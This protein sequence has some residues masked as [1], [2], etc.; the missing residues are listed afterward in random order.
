MNDQ[1]KSSKNEDSIRYKFEELKG[2]AETEAIALRNEIL[3]TEN[4]EKYYNIT[5]NVYYISDKNGN[6]SNDGKTPKTAFKTPNVLEELLLNPG[7]TVL[8][9][10]DNVFRIKNQII[11]SEGVKYGSYGVG[12]KPQLLGS[13]KNYALNTKWHKHYDKPNVWWTEFPHQKPWNVVFDGGRYIGIPK[14]QSDEWCKE[15]Q[16]NYDSLH[17]IFCLYSEKGNPSEVYDDIEI[18]PANCIFTIPWEINDIVIDNLCMKYVAGGA[19]ACGA[20]NNN[21]S[22]TNCEVGYIGGI[23]CDSFKVRMGNAIGFWAGTKNSRVEHNWIYQTFDTAISP[24]G[25]Y[26]SDYINISYSNNLL[27][28]NSVDIEFFDRKGGSFKNFRCDNNIMRFTSLGWGNFFD[29]EQIRG[30]EGNIRAVTSQVE[31]EDFSFSNNIIDCP[32]RQLIN[33]SLRPEQL[34]EFKIEGNKI[35]Y[36]EKVRTKY[37][38]EPPVL[39]GQEYPVPEN[40]NLKIVD[41]R[42]RKIYAN[43]KDEFEI[44]WGLFN[45]K[46]KDEIIFID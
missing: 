44:A 14:V 43:S 32:G 27:E 3:N 34:E 22:V 6:D 45:K 19:L 36:S 2:F 23:L 28:Y 8:F 5:G 26:A 33:W 46:G 15:G 39:T 41:L 21:I 10:R 29:G 12:A 17:G 42:T 35:Y 37:K 25:H 11:C 9:E 20:R 4:T 24:Q 16:F 40:T 30:L 1:T 18:C 31:I 38:E 7:D 13:P